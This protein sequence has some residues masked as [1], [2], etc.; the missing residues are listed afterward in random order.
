MTLTDRQNELQTTTF[1]GAITNTFMK[2]MQKKVVVNHGQRPS[3][4]ECAPCLQDG[5]T[6]MHDAVRIN[7]FKMIK[8]LMMY[9]A[10]LSTKNCVRPTPLNYAERR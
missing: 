9:G 8:L 6:P 2:G 1:L 4:A 3:Y 10:S 5:D 7:R